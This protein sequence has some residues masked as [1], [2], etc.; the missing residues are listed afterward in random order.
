MNHK[1]SSLLLL[2]GLTVLS[3]TV[4]E[5]DLAV[6]NE[7]GLVF[8]ARMENEPR[9][10]TVLQTDGSILWSPQDKIKLFYGIN[11]SSS[12]QLYSNNTSAADEVDFT[13]VPKDVF[14][15]TSVCY[16]IYPGIDEYS[17]FAGPFTVNLP[18]TQTAVAGTFDKDLFISVAK[19][20]NDN[21]YF[22]NVCG[23]ICFTVTESDVTSVV[24]RDN[25]SGMLVG[26]AY[27]Y[28]D[29]ETP[30]VNALENKY[31]ITLS[32]PNGETFVPGE[33]YF[34]VTYPLVLHEG[35]TLLLNKSDG[36]QACKSSSKQVEIKRGVWGY[37]NEVDGELEYVDHDNQIKLERAALQDI[38]NYGDGA[39]WDSYVSMNWCS[40][41]PISEWSGITVNEQGFVTAI[42]I[43]DFHGQLPES[44]GSLKY[45]ERLSLQ[46]QFRGSLPSSVSRLSNLTELCISRAGLLS[47]ATEEGISIAPDFDWSGLNKIKKLEIV[48]QNLTG[49]IPEGLAQLKD[50]EYL[51]LSENKLTGSIPA[52]LCQLTNLKSLNLVSNY[53]S[54]PIPD[55]IGDLTSL[56]E[57]NLKGHS[58]LDT[59][60]D[61]PEYTNSLSGAIPAAL[62]KLSCL[63]Y[64]DLSENQFSGQIPD[65][66]YA[67]SNLEYL[68]LGFNNL[69]GDISERISGLQ[70]LS[71]LN[72]STNLFSGT[73]PE[74]LWTLSSLSLLDLSNFFSKYGKLLENKN[75]F[76]G[77]IS[78]KIANLTNLYFFSVTNCN[79]QGDIPIGIISLGNLS[80]LKLSGNNFSGSIPDGIKDMESL[81][82]FWCQGN[83]LSGYLSE[84]FV[85]IMTEKNQSSPMNWIIS[86][87]Q[88]G[89]DFYYDLYNSSDYSRD[90]E[91]V[92]LNTA[93]IGKGINIVL[94]G[95]GFVDKD[96]QSGFYDET[97]NYMYNALFEIEP[98][99][100]FKDYFNVYAITLV[101]KNNTPIG[102]TALEIKPDPIFVYPVSK[103]RLLSIID[104]LIP[105]MEHDDLTVSIA[106]T[107]SS[108]RPGCCYFMSPDDPD[109]GRLG[110]GYAT[111]HVNDDIDSFKRTVRHEII[112]H[113]FGKLAD[114]YSDRG[115]N[116]ECPDSERDIIEKYHNQNWYLNVD[117]TSDTQ[118]VVWNHFLSIPDYTGSGTGIFEGGATYAHGV[119]RPSYDSIM[120][121][122]VS[123]N[124]PSREA[125][126]KRIHSIAFG[127]EW[128]YDFNEFL[129]WDKKNI[130]S[131]QTSSI[132]TKNHHCQECNKES[133]CI[134]LVK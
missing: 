112:G 131:A 102:E 77:E 128:T 96:I 85:N 34:I 90:K 127:E 16:A 43:Y 76:T 38:F 13:G 42:D 86:P 108:S 49:A 68:D 74:G 1:R 123:F 44:L 24:F 80:T 132:K 124:A 84:G 72:L 103:D 46:G 133:S 20:D 9:S 27:V 64:L 52:S 45:L 55:E 47:L 130:P 105:G 51:R 22:R 5:Q 93:T 134:F 120:R 33:R 91:V 118:S 129:E 122:G 3:C 79:F 63:K 75:N 23:G 89:Y 109:Y 60:E 19:S 28:F 15:V 111:T 48:D 59:Y 67:L 2:C 117:I 53:L 11:G 116:S 56:E 100:S 6:N 39:N 82:V 95:D 29:E 36:T 94:M 126:Y 25:G 54:G 21:L 31:E 107:F 66:L 110:M 26:K 12:V 41:R 7:D 40:D 70:K 35:Y 98:F 101:S 30:K 10:K 32:A 104:E 61:R 57:L 37:L 81:S 115:Y 106:A 114:E 121:N 65:E 18:S 83:Q 88:D 69:T 62:S 4:K 14:N 78:S 71:Y 125:I 87:Q 73:L 92:K 99:K 97:M 17:F 58:T 8:H 113:G 50:L 119:W